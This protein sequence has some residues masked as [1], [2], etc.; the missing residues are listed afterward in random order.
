MAQL[1]SDRRDVD[2]VLHEQLNV[3]ELCKHPRFEDL[4]KKA[5]DIA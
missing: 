5:I 2:F 3:S 1:I 4:N